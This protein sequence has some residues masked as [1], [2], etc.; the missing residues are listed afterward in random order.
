MLALFLVLAAATP[1]QDSLAQ[2][3]RGKGSESQRLHRLF[4]LAWQYDNA[5]HPE[6]ATSR[7]VPGH[8]DRWTETSL[9]AIDRRKREAISLA[10]AVK[11]IDRGKL[12]AKD[13]LDYD[14]FRRNAEEDVEQ[15]KYPREL[16]AITQLAGPQY[17][18][19]T[20]DVMP[21]RT[22]RDYQDILARLRG[23]PERLRQTEALLKKGVETG[24]V[25]PRVVLRDVPAQLEAQTPE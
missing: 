24:V 19:N 18:S 8:N 2:I 4:D 11:S 23:V 1:F 10:E 7:G 14:L 3:A 25:L 12:P 21:A 20:L 16:L 6:L 13:Q 17:L 15:D 9:A 5:Q 22:A